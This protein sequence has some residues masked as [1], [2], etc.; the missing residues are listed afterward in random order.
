MAFQPGEGF[1]S[2]KQGSGGSMISRTSAPNPGRLEGAVFGQFPM[3]KFFLI[4]LLADIPTFLENL[5][6]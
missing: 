3:F 1:G 6:F 2:P 5:E 4:K